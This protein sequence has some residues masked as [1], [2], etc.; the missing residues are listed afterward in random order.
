LYFEG[1]PL[2]LRLSN[3]QFSVGACRAGVQSG[4]EWARIDYQSMNEVE[5]F[6]PPP[7][8]RRN[9]FIQAASVVIGG[10]LGLFPFLAG[11]RVYLDPLSRKGVESSAVKV[12]TIDSVPE[13]GTPKKFTVVAGRTD[14]W[15]RIPP[16][17]IGAVYLRRQ[18]EDVVA[19]S[20]VCPHAGCFVDYRA[21]EHQDFFCPC[22]NSN[23]NSDGSIKAGVS[24]RSMDTLEVERRGT[25][26]AE[27]WVTFQSFHAGHA[28][29][30]PI[31]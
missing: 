24:P 15:N 4:W 30:T 28:E 21:G 29:K 6:P 17:P 25:N 19:F 31:T 2:T 1:A 27:I 12:A 11:L 18:G 13:D 23:F 10:F 5:V 8:N 3:R 20:T 16:A 22:H 7:P 26:G 9:F 14:V